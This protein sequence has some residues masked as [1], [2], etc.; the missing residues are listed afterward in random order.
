[1]RTDSLSQLQNL[2]PMLACK[3]NIYEIPPIS[4]ENFGVLISGPARRADLTLE[5]GLESR[6]VTD[7]GGQDALP[8]LACTLEKLW[9]ARKYRGAAAPGRLPGEKWDLTVEDY[10]LIGGI[11]G[12]VAA[13]AENCWN[14][15]NENLVERE[16]VR[17][18]V[19]VQ[20][21]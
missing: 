1:M 10:E 19:S 13:I 3:V 15:K 7:S 8:L 11:Q 4:S 16:A 12:I 6:L 2:K 9:H 5:P 20:G 17:E 18:A 21:G 14:Q